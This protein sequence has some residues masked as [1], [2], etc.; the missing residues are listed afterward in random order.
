MNYTATAFSSLCR[1]THTQT[2][3]L[4]YL[5]S[6]SNIEQVL[7]KCTN[8]Q[9]TFEA[10]LWCQGSSTTQSYVRLEKK[11]CVYVNTFVYL[12]SLSFGSRSRW[13]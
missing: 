3:T 11:F 2:H 6:I 8:N 12:F 4:F 10:D 1:D 7:L 5:Y 13:L 9:R